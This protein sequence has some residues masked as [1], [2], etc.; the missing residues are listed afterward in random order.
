[1]PGIF[2]IHPEGGATIICDTL[3]TIGTAEHLIM[4]L[5][6]KESEREKIVYSEGKFDGSVINS[7]ASIVTVELEFLVNGDTPEEVAS[8]VAALKVAFFNFK[9]GYMEYRPIGYSAS[10]ISTFYRYLQSTPP[11]RIN[12]EV[13]IQPSSEYFALG[14]MYRFQIKIF[15]LA[16]SDPD[17]TLGAITSGDVWTYTEGAEEGYLVL[18]SSSIK[19]DGL[20]PIISIE[21]YVSPIGA[22]TDEF[23]MSFYEIE[24]GSEDL[25]WYVAGWTGDPGVTF[26]TTDRFTSSSPLPFWHVYWP[27]Q[28]TSRKPFGKCTPIISYRTTETDWKIRLTNWQGQSLTSN[29]ITDWYDLENT[30]GQWDVVVLETINIPPSLYPD[31]I[32][33]A[34][35]TQYIGLEVYRD[36][37]PG[38]GYVNVYGLLLTPTDGN[39]W[40]AQFERS[41]LLSV[42][43]YIGTGRGVSVNCPAGANY[44]FF[45]NPL[46]GD[47]THAWF[48]KGMPIREAIMPKGTYQIRYLGPVGTSRWSHDQGDSDNRMDMTVAGQFY[49]IY[50]FKES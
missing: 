49:T 11:Q 31:V 34:N 7:T 46:T 16:T 30:T 44:Y 12:A 41:G 20:F 3:D 43:D 21:G 39:A 37:T 45:D 17:D 36:G 2:Q 8:N 4:S 13:I 50:P 28:N 6:L 19:G 23:I 38:V 25:D 33:L 48:K 10:V 15:S 42:A 32:P 22:Q 27:V 35:L 9:G 26:D 1:M 14:E 29:P 5:D 24:S 40:I 47:F 18:N